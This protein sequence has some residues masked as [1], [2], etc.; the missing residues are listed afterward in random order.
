MLLFPLSLL[1]LEQANGNPSSWSDI[2]D[3]TYVIPGYNTGYKNPEDTTY[4]NQKKDPPTSA[5]WFELLRV[6][7]ADWPKNILKWTA[8][9]G[10]KTF[11]IDIKD[12]L[13]KYPLGRFDTSYKD[14]KVRGL[15]SEGKLIGRCI[16]VHT[17]MI[18][19]VQTRMS[20]QGT[21]CLR[22]KTWL[23]MTTQALVRH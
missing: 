5:S 23:I 12:P 18:L 17:T 19:N 2:R 15:Y 8:G 21:T 11:E 4:D 7:T 3:T 22:R 14:I 20:I 16:V 10:G 9:S 6:L 1:L 13:K